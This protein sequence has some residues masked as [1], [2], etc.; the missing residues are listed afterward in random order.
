MTETRSAATTTRPTEGEASDVFAAARWFDALWNSTA[1]AISPDQV[2]WQCNTW[3]SGRGCGDWLDTAIFT[4]V[5]QVFGLASGRN[6][7]ERDELVVFVPLDL[8]PQIE[9]LVERI[10]EIA[11]DWPWF[12]E[13]DPERQIILAAEALGI[14]AAAI[15]EDADLLEALRIE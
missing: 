3:G 10:G 1:K 5:A 14:P 7:D 4:L 8:F 12:A 2:E 13:D 6:R 9:R 15:A 11:E